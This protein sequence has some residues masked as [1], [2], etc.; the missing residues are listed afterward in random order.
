[1][2][3]LL[4]RGKCSR[5]KHTASS[6]TPPLTIERAVSSVLV[7]R[8][9]PELSS[10]NIN[11]L[12]HVGESDSRIRTG[13]PHSHKHSTPTSKSS[14]R[15]LRKRSKSRL[16]PQKRTV[17]QGNSLHGAFEVWGMCHIGAVGSLACRQAPLTSSRPRA[18]GAGRLAG[19]ESACTLLTPAQQIADSPLLSDMK[20]QKHKNFLDN[21]TDH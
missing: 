1:M 15:A 17:S 13:A 20:T 3:G 8:P 11:S 16:A 7:Q 12:K 10:Q 19:C 5:Q 9:P 21:F 14:Y 2:S 6:N 4:S 18:P